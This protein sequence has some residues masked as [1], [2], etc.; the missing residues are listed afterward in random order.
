MIKAIARTM[1]KY[2][3]GFGTNPP[4]LGLMKS[5]LIAF[6]VGVRYKKVEVSLG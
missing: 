2:T 3:N 6:R 5:P 4:L 1:A